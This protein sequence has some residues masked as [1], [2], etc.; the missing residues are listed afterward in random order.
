MAGVTIK[1]WLK[2][3]GLDRSRLEDGPSAIVFM[4][5]V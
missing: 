4:I 1:G 5:F 2:V 3:V